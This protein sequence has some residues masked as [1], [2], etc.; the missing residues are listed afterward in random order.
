MGS[1]SNED[2]MKIARLARLKINES[3]IDKYA[4]NL[5]SIFEEVESLKLVDTANVEP[6][7]SVTD[8]EM[9]TRKDEVTDGNYLQKILKNAKDAKY[10]CY[11]VP[12]VIE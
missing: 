4:D 9:S 3:E 8:R 7:V 5:N 12:K 2:V 11:S 1:F 10:N 6:L